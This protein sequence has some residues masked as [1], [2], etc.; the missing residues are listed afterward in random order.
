MAQ[1]N[2]NNRQQNLTL[3]EEE[4]GDLSDRLQGQFRSALAQARSVLSAEELLAWGKEGLTLARYFPPS[5]VE[6]ATEYFQATPEVLDILPFTHFL[7]WVQGGKTL[8]R[9]YP[10]L[11]TAYFQASPQALTMFPHRLTGVWMEIGRSLYRDTPESIAL[12]RDF[13]TATPVLLQS[14]SLAK[15][16]RL[17]LFLNRLAETHQD[18]AAECL[19]SAIQVLPKIE[20]EEQ[21][22]FLSLALTLVRTNPKLAAS[23][24]ER[25]A[26]ALAKIERGQQKAFLSLT[27]KMARTGAQRASAFFFDCSQAFHRIDGSLH[28]QLLHWGETVLA[29]SATAGIE[30]LKSCPSLLARGG[31]A[32]LERWFEEGVR[33]LRQDQEAGL[34]Y[35]RLESVDERTLERL[36]ARVDLEQVNRTLLMYS[37]A[38][39][40][41]KVQIQSTDGLKERNIGWVHPDRPTTDGT[42]IFVPA[43]MDRYNSK[44]ENFSWYKVAVTHQAG[45]IEF[46]TF[47]FSF[48]KEASLFH[49]QRPQLPSADGDGLTD[50][51]RF[52]SLFEDR[53]LSTD[54]FA[55]VEDTRV[56]YL[57]KQAYAGIRSSYQQ[58]QRESLSSRPPV[59]SLPLREAFIEILIRIS[60]DGNPP[61]LPPVIRSQ[62]ESAVQLLRRMQ[63]AGATVED[64]AEA[65]L[66]LYQIIS[67]IPNNRLTEGQ[68]DTAEPT[69]GEF[70]VIN[71]SRSRE[72]RENVTPRPNTELSY[73]SPPE[74]EFR[75]S[76]NPELVQ[77]QLKLKE[78]NHPYGMYPLSPEELQNL[79]GKEIELNGVLRG[80]HSSSGLYVTDLP[81]EAQAKDVFSDKPGKN[82]D[83]LGTVKLVAETPVDEEGQFFFYDE[84]DFQACCYLPKWC[85]VKEKPLAEGSTDFFEE[86]LTRNSSLAA[87]IR[88]QFE[89]LAP[90]L[91]KKLNKLDDGEELD[92]DAVIEAVVERK[93]GYSPSEKIYWKRRKIQR[94]VAAIFLLDMSGSTDNT[95]EDTDD[96]ED[97]FD[98][99]LDP[100][101]ALAQSRARRAQGLTK[102]PRRVIDVAKESIVMMI[103]ALEAA[104]DCYGIYGFSGH[105]RDNVELLV[106]KGI[107]EKFSSAVKRRVDTI[108]PR[109]STRMGPAIRH[110]VS[111]LD[112]HVAKTKILFMVSDGY[113]QDKDYGRDS[114]DRE[115]A[116]QDTRMALIEAKRKNITPFCLTIDSAGYDY[117]RKMSQDIGYEVVN[118]IESL[119]QRLPLLYK[120]LTS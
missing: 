49:N 5:S 91:L 39:A 86:T 7:D 33:I 14:L 10:S 88:K 43:S 96:E 66:C 102:E 77:L 50:I 81:A 59:F 1:N 85:R 28:S 30:F 118:N 48:E 6:A 47:N 40:G 72:H 119:P 71:N 82:M 117:L 16:E 78:D 94:D 54:I 63:S 9:H 15:L 21:G 2:L 93:A 84:W 75:G 55:L 12:V 87:R 34:T 116:L 52:F 42:T 108:T 19:N 95:I 18:L 13:F 44:E 76:S 31:I 73:Q 110:A 24:F 100:M 29:M 35:F 38:L 109:H 70:Y 46:G 32:D 99:Y 80:E 115:Y 37:Q 107:D 3:I 51:G 120:R 79:D 25:G 68:W 112:T 58:I 20:T 103:N 67:T 104:G 89:M 26:E 41:T 111:K 53:K 61:V 90:E 8:C 4:L 74:V 11:A 83:K 62:L 27:E 98:W 57:L 113:P 106:V 60:L 22:H 23:Y 114:N 56:D 64:S 97:Y 101:E 17:V 92:L 69:E 65:T 105:G 36:S 45:H